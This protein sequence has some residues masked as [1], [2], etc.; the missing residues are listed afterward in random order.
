MA[1]IGARL[2][3]VDNPRGPADESRK[4]KVD[5]YGDPLPPQAKARLG[6]VRMRHAAMVHQVAF[7]PGGKVL[8]T[9]TQDGTVC[10]W[11][12]AT[13][14]ELKRFRTMAENQL[15]QNV[16]F[17]G[18]AGGVFFTSMVMPGEIA[19]SADGKMLACGGVDGGVHLWDVAAGKELRKI[20]I[21][22]FPN[23][24]AEMAFAPDGKMLALRSYDSSIR[25]FEVPGGKKIRDLEKKADNANAA[26]FYGGEQS[27]AFTPDGK[28][29]VSTKGENANGK[30]VWHLILHDTTTGKELRRITSDD[31]GNMPMC[32]RF[33]PDGKTLAWSKFDGSYQ[34]AEVATG[35]LGRQLKTNTLLPGELLF[36]ADGTKLITRSANFG[37]RILDLATGKETVK[38]GTRQSR[39][40]MSGWW[41][42][43]RG[44]IALSADEKLFALPTNN[45]TVRL[46]DLAANRERMFGSGHEAGITS[47]EYT[48]DGTAIY[49]QSSDGT[50]RIWD[51]ATGKESRRA[52][53]P[54]EGPTR[55]VLSPNGN[56]LLAALNDNRA[57]LWDAATGKQ[58]HQLQGP[59]NGVC[60]LAF[61]PDGKSAA[62][63]GSADKAAYI[64]LYD[65]ATGKERRQIKVPI[66]TADNAG[67]PVA[68][69]TSPLAGMSFSPD[70]RL[71]AAPITSQSL[72]LWD[73]AT[74]KELLAIQ[75]P[76]QRM[77]QSAT[78]TPDS[79]C[80]ALDVGEDSFRLY[81][82]ASGKERRTYGKKPPASGDTIALNGGMMAGVVVVGGGFMGGVN[83][84]YTRPAPTAVFS[85]DGR[86]AAMSRK[87]QT[88]SVWDIA[89]GKE[90]A[91]LK[92]HQGAVETLVFAPDGESLATGSKDTT[93]LIWDLTGLPKD[94]KQKAKDLDPE[95]RWKDLAGDDASRAFDAI[96]ELAGDPAKALPFLRAHV[97]PAAPANAETIQRLI[98]ELDSDQFAR[99]RQ[100]S[101]ELEK[102]GQS[103][104][105][106]LRKALEGD[107]S[108]EARKR[109]ESL[110]NKMSLAAPRGEALRTLRAIEVLES[111][112][113]PEARQLL[114]RLGQGV[115][116]ASSTQAA[117]A[118][119]E[120]MK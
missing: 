110:L 12:L 60:A 83:L 25:L 77:I 96:L 64:W 23:G 28:I 35:K 52:K 27:L 81:E 101:Q 91:Q 108:A 9:V 93:G 107:P 51:P 67:A 18:G 72:G 20:E 53:L 76:D 89:T 117:K 24:V 99:R 10:Q 75:T 80:L 1:A 44:S 65:T 57:G 119:L 113:T 26:A 79:R 88:I 36:S 73:V 11:D 3:A 49:S 118:A 103:A 106:F 114:Q 6:T 43:S 58:L 31:Q 59:K 14:K 111:I 33:S 63:Y 82:V 34:F 95:A 90:L 7:L 17:F 109:I 69:P 54:H 4:E 41:G 61:S 16:A 66:P 13:G 39:V 85:P 74:G 40:V 45:H 47:L 42:N 22:D 84:P 70:G 105:P 78:F 29:L 2:S 55:F 19:I 71:V 102:V 38:L 120:R 32:P 15:A 50:L 98:A 5:V 56:V 8:L 48:R 92:G 30:Q 87:N 46:L 116:E 94:T 62:V 104:M 100:A 86:L 112:G 68:V 21:G 37:L 97:Q 115:P